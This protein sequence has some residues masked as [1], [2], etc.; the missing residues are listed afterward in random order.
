MGLITIFPF[1]VMGEG[2]VRTVGFLE[3]RS[4]SLFIGVKTFTYLFLD[5][6]KIKNTK[7]HTT[8]LKSHLK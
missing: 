7:K 8:Y 2:V 1:L 5:I 6:Y 4:Y 3:P